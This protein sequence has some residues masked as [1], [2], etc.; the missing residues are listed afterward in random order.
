MIGKKIF[1]F[2][3]LLGSQCSIAAEDAL[4]SI[5]VYLP[6]K[7]Q[8]VEEFIEHIAQQTLFKSCSVMILDTTEEN[9][10]EPIITALSQRYPNIYYRNLG[11]DPGLVPSLNF[12]MWMASCPYVTAFLIDD[13]Y[14][15][16]LLMRELTTMMSKKGCELVYSDCQDT[17]AMSHQA[18]W[19]NHVH[20][21][22]GYFM[23][24][25]TELYLHEFITRITARGARTK[26]L[27]KAGVVHTINH[28]VV[29]KELVDYE[30]WQSLHT[31]AL[32]D[33]KPMVIVIP[34]Y[35]N[36][37]WIEQN[38]LS[39][40]CQHYTNYRVIYLNDA[41]T[42]NTA[43]A[44]KAFIESHNQEARFTVINNQERVGALANIYRAVQACYP[45]EIV[46]MLDGDDW[47]AHRFVL[48]AINTLYANPDV[49]VTYG[50]FMIWP[51]GHPGWAQKVPIEWLKEKRARDEQWSASH[52]RTC[53]AGLFQK[54]LVEDL[55]FEGKFW[56]MAWDLA[57]MF[58]MIEMAGPEHSRFMPEILYLYNRATGLNDDIVDQ[59]QQTR[60]CTI[61]REKKPYD[62]L[63][64][65]QF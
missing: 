56:Q 48:N 3:L 34:S 6:A 42:D 24:Q 60:L 26:K 62:N 45:E 51:M 16:N 54:I 19:R 17:A 49:W 8:N 33:E 11:W 31:T 23:Q 64:A 36:E 61:I 20:Y 22:Y 30:Q 27:E 35:N 44:V 53:Y 37:R 38:L 63:E 7:A 28:E 65:L 18:L 52:L 5:I 1:L 58:P 21:H 59:R 2:L 39:V 47:L 10:K 25:Y 43:N 50:Q 41:S 32:V 13:R 9:S 55:I 46:I 29:K 40:V 4:I 14:P 12:G 57:I 15:A